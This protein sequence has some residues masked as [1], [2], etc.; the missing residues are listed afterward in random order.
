LPEKLGDLIKAKA[1]LEQHAKNAHCI[2]D[3]QI[4]QSLTNIFEKT[5]RYDNLDY[6]SNINS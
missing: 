4:A 2:E 3:R 6:S 5:N 1:Q